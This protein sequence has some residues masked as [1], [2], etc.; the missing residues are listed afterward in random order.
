M[1]DV[2]R[3]SPGLV[4][5][6]KQWSG[7]CAAPSASPRGAPPSGGSGLPETGTGACPPRPADTRPSGLEADRLL[8]APGTRWRHKLGQLVRKVL[9]TTRFRSARLPGFGDCRLS[10][11]Y[12]SP[13]GASS[14]P[15]LMD[16]TDAHFFQYHAEIGDNVPYP[17]D[18]FDRPY[19][20]ALQAKAGQS[21]PSI[22]GAL[23]AQGYSG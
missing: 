9:G 16:V 23:P 20:F 6:G 18:A 14:L 7:F 17:L 10:T 22:H 4:P 15:S 21:S 19:D 8:R 5:A 1:R 2:F 13:W 3:L 12:N 11:E